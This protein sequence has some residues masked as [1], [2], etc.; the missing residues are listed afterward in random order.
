MWGWVGGG[1][2]EK[3]TKKEKKNVFS[4]AVAK[5]F[6]LTQKRKEE[7]KRETKKEGRITPFACF[8]NA[9]LTVLPNEF[10]ISYHV[11]FRDRLGLAL[12]INEEMDCVQV[13]H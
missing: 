5:G 9:F 4:S 13:R 11:L 3:E 7:R 1:V 10:C 6:V 12:R 8:C 2:R